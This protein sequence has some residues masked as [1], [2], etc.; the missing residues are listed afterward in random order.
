[1]K[2]VCFPLIAAAA[3]GFFVSGCIFGPEEHHPGRPAGT[4]GT[5]S[6]NGSWNEVNKVYRIDGNL[7]IEASVVWNKGITI[8][9]D[10]GAVISIAGNGSLTIREGVTLRFGA[11][12]YLSAGE[13]TV[14]SLLV[15]GTDSLPVQFLPAATSQYWGYDAG[16]TNMDGSGGIWIGDYAAGTTSIAHCIIDHATSGIFVKK[17]YFPISDCAVSSSK[18]YGIEFADGAGPADTAAFCRDTIRNCGSYPMVIPAASIGR[19]SGDC[20]FSGNGKTAVKATS[21]SDVES[22]AVWRKQ[23]VPYLFVSRTDI[24]AI[25]GATVTIRPGAAFLFE[26]GAYIE[27]GYTN[28]GALIADGTAQEPISFA[29]STAGTYWGYETNAP[30]DG[31]GGLWFGSHTTSLTSLNYCTFARATTGIYAEGAHLAISNSKISVCKYYGIEFGSDA[32]PLDSASFL[33]DTCTSNGTYGIKISAAQLSRLSGIGSVS[34]N[35]VGGIFVDANGS[36][37]D[38]EQTGTWKK[39]D[40]PYVVH[41]TIDIGSIAGDSLIILPGAQFRFTDDSYI[42]VGLGNPGALIAVGTVSD[43]ISFTS[44]TSSIKWGYGTEENSSGGIYF[45]SQA[46]TESALKYCIVEKATAGVYVDAN[47]TIQNC[48]LR[49]NDHHGIAITSSAA[50]PTISNNSYSGNCAAGCVGTGDPYTIP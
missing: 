44:H 20:S 34:G 40:S 48:S 11:G 15:Q 25:A 5:I 46:T 19:L 50:S 41:G 39:Q 22:D 4:H 2:R 30:G 33:Y 3:A 28:P 47:V 27:V 31:S 49:N 45:E 35:T 9:V 42:E 36:N 29:N 13:Y 14:G 17:G 7:S 37:G 10:D 38:I 12:A 32:G 23:D 16:A 6:Q 43:S 24:G 8:E 1:M 18:Y 21:A 26:T